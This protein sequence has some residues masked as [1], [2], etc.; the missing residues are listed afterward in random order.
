[1][2]IGRNNN[3]RGQRSKLAVR[4]QSERSQKGATS[5][6]FLVVFI[7]I[8]LSIAS[9]AYDIGHNVDVRSQL[10]S[11]ADAAAI[12]G[13]YDLCLSGGNGDITPTPAMAL[14]YATL[15][16]VDAAA[17]AKQNWS[18]GK[19]IDASEITTYPCQFDLPKKTPRHGY[20]ERYFMTVKI[21]KKIF[22]IFATLY[23]HPFDT[24][25]VTSVAGPIGSPTSVTS[26]SSPFPMAIY[27]PNDGA[28]TRTW[29]QEAGTN[30]LSLGILPL[31]T[32]NSTMQFVSGPTGLLGG[33]L[34]TVGVGGNGGPTL[35]QMK[36]FDPAQA[37]CVAPPSQTV[38]QT[39]MLMNPGVTGLNLSLTQAGPLTVEDYMQ[40][41][42]LTPGCFGLTVGQPSYL[43][44][45]APFLQGKSFVV[46][47]VGNP[48]CSILSM[49]LA[50]IL[51]GGVG[52]QIKGFAQVTFA[53]S[54][55]QFGSGLSLL[56]IVILPS[57]F[58]VT[59]TV[60]SGGMGPVN[61]GLCN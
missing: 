45:L 8:S 55:A 58:N 59:G 6:V 26:V 29:K 39:L 4:Q 5:G 14:S 25:S 2:R 23:G 37:T 12:A 52:A 35:N 9:F 40:N 24:I 56:G 50:S 32:N 47:V 31:L 22:N 57:T 54:N 16:S 36:Y 27:Q 49:P 53:S 1:M 10:Q 15:A 28:G 13:A 51:K 30:T 33:T 41:G 48:T 60:K 21:E 17:I 43:P 44:K 38:G 19:N 61:I 11:A 46:P 3:H 34:A 7:L 20:D 42:C 18:D